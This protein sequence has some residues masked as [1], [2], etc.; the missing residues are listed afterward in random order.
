[1]LQ[2]RRNAQE[3]D[4]ADRLEAADWWYEREMLLAQGAA[5][6]RLW[7]GRDAPLAAMR[8]ALFGAP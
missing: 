7:T 3:A 5:S 6:F 1:M 2:A 8:A 4:R